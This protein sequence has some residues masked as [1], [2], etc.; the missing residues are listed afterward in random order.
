MNEVINGKSEK[1]FLS[2][3]LENRC[4]CGSWLARHDHGC[5][6]RGWLP[7]LLR[8]VTM[9][10]YPSFPK[11]VETYEDAIGWLFGNLPPD[12]LEAIIERQAP[13]PSVG[14]FILDLHWISESKLRHDLKRR[15]YPE[16]YSNTREVA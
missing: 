9:A 3:L 15:W 16:R 4:A 5:G 13:L 12:E 10:K 7:R 11:P 8:A 2:H 1:S 14:K 6:L